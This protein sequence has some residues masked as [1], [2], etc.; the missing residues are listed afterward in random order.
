[1]AYSLFTKVSVSALLLCAVG[2]SHTL[3]KLTP[4]PPPPPQ[5]LWT[6]DKAAEVRG[7]VNLTANR[8]AEGI[9]ICDDARLWIDPPHNLVVGSAGLTLYS[10][11][12]YIRG[13]G[14]ITSS[15]STLD[16]KMELGGWQSR[17]FFI[18]T[19]VSDYG[20]RSVGIRIRNLKKSYSQLVMGGGFRNTFTGDV[21]VSGAGVILSLSKTNCGNLD[22]IDE[23][24][25]A[26][27]V[28]GN[29]W[30]RDRAELNLWYND[31]IAEASSLKLTNSKLSLGGI[32]LPSSRVS[33]V[34]SKLTVEGEVG[35]DYHK[36][37]FGDSERFLY[38]GELVIS[39]HSFLRIQNWKEGRDH[40]LVRRDS[41][42]LE[43]SLKR[44]AFEGYD[45]NAV[46][47]EDYDKDYWE[48]NAMPEPV[49]YGAG[50][51]VVSFGLV[52][53]RRYQRRH[54][55]RLAA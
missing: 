30:V 16:I 34:L 40:L 8:E 5:R 55:P 17:M 35:I 54:S 1:M 29:I 36:T 28:N 39:D 31:Q 3:A 15:N 41:A 37:D 45:P 42:H 4:P 32:H 53:Y 23:V 13:D 20:G 18:D 25:N 24:R 49:A 19:V 14:S 46:H 6:K 21:E 38:L 33:Q 43:E 47:L 12:G 26:G 52:G 22:R 9:S 44:I 2:A 11:V 7:T 10:G 27:A 50:L 51:G 48:I